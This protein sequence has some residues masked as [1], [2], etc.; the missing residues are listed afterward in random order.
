[1]ILDKIRCSGWCNKVTL[2]P[3]TPLLHCLLIYY[4]CDINICVE[5]GSWPNM[6][7]I[8]FCPLEPGVTWSHLKVHLESTR[9][10]ETILFW[11]CDTVYWAVGP[12]IASKPI[13]GEI[14]GHACPNTLYIQH[15]SSHYDGFFLD[16]IC[17]LTMS[18]FIGLWNPTSWSMQFWL[19]SSCSCLCFYCACR[20][21]PSWWRHSCVTG[22]NQR[23]SGV[24]IA[25]ICSLGALDHQCRDLHPIKLL[26]LKEDRASS[27][28]TRPN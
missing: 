17:H 15:P 8:R 25:R 5:N 23:S 14:R 12:C 1:M 28:I 20:D 26:Y 21:K 27:S 16:H 7:C 2:L 3:F 13:R 18:S 22:D 11:C 4:T 19:R 10:V 6:L 24:V 9:I